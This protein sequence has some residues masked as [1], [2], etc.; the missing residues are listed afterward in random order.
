MYDE[1]E[2]DKPRGDDQI[3][4]WRGLREAFKSAV[5]GLGELFSALLEPFR[6]WR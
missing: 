3:K 5:M 6:Y 2:P 1:P 4:G